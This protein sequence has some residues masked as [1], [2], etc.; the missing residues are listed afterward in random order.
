MKIGI[1][2][3]GAYVPKYRIKVEEIARIWGQEPESIKSGLGVFEKSVADVDEDT[4]TISVEAAQNALARAQIDPEKIEALFVGS[5]SHPYTVKPSGTIV[6]EV[7][8]ITPNVLVADLEFACKAGTAGIQICYGLVKSGEME[9]GMAIGA[10]TAQGRPG[11]ALEYTAAGGGAAVIIGKNPLAIIEGMTS[12][13]TDT[14]DFWRREGQDYPK[15]GA[16][17]TGKPAYFRHVLSA[18]K[19]LMEK[20]SLKESDFDYYVFHMP[21]GKFPREA[22]KSLGF[23]LKKLEQSLVVRHIGNTYSG[24]SMLGLCNVLDVA[25][26]GQRILLTSFGSGAGSDSFSLMVTEEILKRRELAPKTDFYINR[27]EYIDY[28]K[29]VKLRK[30]LKL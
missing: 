22:A 8:G 12:F 9:Y 27:K 14:P 29:Y 17:F 20:M 11:D 13:T 30:K 23:D 5:E 10:D 24:S 7:L 15:H 25:K 26:P 6:A 28:G 4:V 19:A 16:R 21:N 3:Y 1:A 2:G 18:T